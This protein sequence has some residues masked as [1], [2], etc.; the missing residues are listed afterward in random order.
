M[1]VLGELSGIV[2][3]PRRQLKLSVANDPSGS[4]SKDDHLTIERDI[5]AFDPYIL[6]K[7]D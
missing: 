4:R 3:Q 2:E 7:N 5:P 1:Y 6:M